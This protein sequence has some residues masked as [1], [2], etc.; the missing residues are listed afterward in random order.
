[1][2]R[3]GFSTVVSIRPE[4]HEIQF[5]SASSRDRNSMRFDVKSYKAKSFGDDFQKEFAGCLTEFASKN[6]SFAGKS[7]WMTVVLPNRLVSTS[8]F[9]IPGLSKKNL[10]NLFNVALDSNYP[11]RRDLKINTLLVKQNKQY[12]TYCVAIVRQKLMQTLYA[13]CNGANMY[14]NLLTYKG[15][16]TGYGAVMLSPKLGNETCLVYD[17]KQNESTLTFLTK[18]ALTL[19]C[20]DLPFGW[21]ILQSQKPVAENMLFNHDV[22]ELAVLNAKEKAKAKALTMLG[23]Q[24]FDNDSNFVIDEDGEFIADTPD[25]QRTAVPTMK[26]LPRKTPRVLPKWM[27]RPVPDTRE[28]VVYE[29]FRIFV[30]YALEF[31]RANARLT[32]IGVPS[33][34]YVNM[35]D[36]Y[37]YLFELVNEESSENRIKF[38]D[39]GL[40]KEKAVIREHLDLYGGLYADQFGSLNNF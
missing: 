36:E 5:F 31:V 20:M 15:A 23:G 17:I 28:G 21:E 11:N 19:G 1:M 30:K 13:T 35:P 12:S 7:A 40:K 18:G 8:S 3:N 39:L 26:T 33:T 32:S 24:G 25:V 29:N 14:P 37:E 4:E 34:V 2:A 22:A 38:A 10:S 9:N 6:P 16:A 27:Q